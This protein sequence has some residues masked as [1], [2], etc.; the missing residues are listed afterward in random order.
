MSEKQLFSST[1]GRQIAESFRYWV[2]VV[3]VTMAITAAVGSVDAS[4]ADQGVESLSEANTAFAW[5][6]YKRQAESA[7]AARSQNIFMSPFSIS[8]ALAMT[9]LGARAQ[10]RTQMRQVLHF[11]DVQNDQIVHRAFGNILSSL[12]QTQ[13]QYKLYMANRLFG[14]KTYA[15]LEEFLSA[16]HEH[17]DVE[18]A[19]VDFR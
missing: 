7:A 16:V 1:V 19:P 4:S 13:D 18:L 8:V 11:N 3:I 15:F 12:N 14:E 10:T 6:L 9:Y 2:L 5:D 17:Y